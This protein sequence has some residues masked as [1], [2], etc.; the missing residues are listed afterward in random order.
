MTTH[1]SLGRMASQIKTVAFE[2]YGAGNRLGT[3]EDK[4]KFWGLVRYFTL[5]FSEQN[6]VDLYDLTLYKCGLTVHY[7]TANK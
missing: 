7:P 2:K 4:G 1:Q 5:Q 6:T 3:N